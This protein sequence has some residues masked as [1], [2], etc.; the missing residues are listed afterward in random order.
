MRGGWERGYKK[1]PA[2]FPSCRIAFLTNQFLTNLLSA[3]PDGQRG[4]GYHFL[5]LVTVLYFNQSILF[6]TFLAVF[7][8]C[9]PEHL[10]T[11]FLKKCVSQSYYFKISRCAKNLS[12]TNQYSQ[13][14]LNSLNVGSFHSLRV[15]C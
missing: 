13:Y 11:L 7:V 5:G 1:Q 12:L 8:F 4:V 3:S 15:Y 10:R 14:C 6:L 9:R 2:R